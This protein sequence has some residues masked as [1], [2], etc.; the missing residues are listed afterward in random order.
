MRLFLILITFVMISFSFAAEKL[1]V[2]DLVVI[3]RK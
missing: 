1:Q 2:I 3:G